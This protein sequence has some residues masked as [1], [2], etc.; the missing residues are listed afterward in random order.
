MAG[1]LIKEEAASSS[2]SMPKKSTT[3]FKKR[4]GDNIIASTE[5]I[6]DNPVSKRA[7]MAKD[8]YNYELG[9]CR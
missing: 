8:G 2:S 7:R 4:K 1:E 5:V 9:M 3:E 6:H